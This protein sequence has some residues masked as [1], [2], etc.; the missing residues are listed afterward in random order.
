[1]NEADWYEIAH[2]RSLFAELPTPGR[3]GTGDYWTATAFWGRKP[4]PP[5]FWQQPRGKNAGD[6]LAA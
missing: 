3:R 1:M 2:G 4:K 5:L 6:R